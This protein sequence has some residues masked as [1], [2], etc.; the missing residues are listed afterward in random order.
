MLGDLEYKDHRRSLSSRT[1]RTL[2]FCCLLVVFF[3]IFNLLPSRGDKR[4]TL[5]SDTTV[6]TE[7][8]QHHEEEFLE[9]P[10]PA[11]DVVVEPPRQQ[12]THGPQMVRCETSKGEL[13]IRVRPD[14]APHGAKRF[15]ELV[16]AGFF[17]QN[18]IYRVPPMES[19]SI[20]QFGAQPNQKLVER[21]SA[22]TIPDDAPVSCAGEPVKCSAREGATRTTG[23]S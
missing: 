1:Q 4:E 18:V 11:V 23:I 7:V 12:H 21:F 10:T 20:H 19:N 22:V 3:T 14:W 15:L 17:T 16:K 8:E 13:L 5:T 6:H 9:A 2:T